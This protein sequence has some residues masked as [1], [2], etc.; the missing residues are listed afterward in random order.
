LVG[1]GKIEKV[2]FAEPAQGAFFPFNNSLWFFAKTILVI[3]NFN[4]RQAILA[5]VISFSLAIEANSREEK[6]EDKLSA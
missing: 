3:G 2:Q 5:E 4:K 6:V 1:G